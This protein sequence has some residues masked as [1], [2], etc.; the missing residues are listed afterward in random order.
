FER[1][2]PHSLGASIAGFACRQHRAVG[3]PG[4][5]SRC[6]MAVAEI[7]LATIRDLRQRDR[8]RLESPSASHRHWTDSFHTGGRDWR[9][10]CTADRIRSREYS[11]LLAAKPGAAKIAAP[12]RPALRRVNHRSEEHTSE[13]QSRGHLV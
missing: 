2:A 7:H 6:Y 1:G 3:H 9:R 13:L 10:A 11:N 8:H 5:I 4:L 12:A